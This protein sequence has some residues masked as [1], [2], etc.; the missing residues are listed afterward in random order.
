MDVETLGEAHTPHAG[1]AHPL[2]A[3]GLGRSPLTPGGVGH[4]LFSPVSVLGSV[5]GLRLALPKGARRVATPKAAGRC[6]LTAPS[7]RADEPLEVNDDECGSPNTPGCA[8]RRLRRAGAGAL[9]PPVWRSALG[10]TETPRPRSF[11]LGSN[12]VGFDAPPKACPP[13]PYRPT[14]T[15]LARQDSLRDT[16]L[17]VATSA[18]RSRPCRVHPRPTHIAPHSHA[19]ARRDAV[20]TRESDGNHQCGR[21]GGHGS[22]VFGW[23]RRLCAVRL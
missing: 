16:K 14:R 21:G 6:P 18:V 20:E 17:L 2:A 23:L 7:R 13:T 19:A 1:G 11:V 9:V 4:D 3:L 22:R 10:L 5:N 12:A 15:P 8:R